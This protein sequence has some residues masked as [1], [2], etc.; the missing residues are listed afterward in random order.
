MGRVRHPDG[1]AVR[2]LALTLPH[3]IGVTGIFL[4]EPISDATSGIVA[5]I[6]FYVTYRSLTRGR[7]A[8][9]AKNR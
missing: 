9:D 6:L 5:G 7:I 4:A 8:D 3:W 1:R 2:P